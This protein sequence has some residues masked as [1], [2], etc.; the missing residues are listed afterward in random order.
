MRRA[1]S[2][3]RRRWVGPYIWRWRAFL[4]SRFRRCSGLS[5]TADFASTRLYDHRMKRH[6]VVV[7]VAVPIF[8]VLARWN[9]VVAVLFAI[10]VLTWILTSLYRRSMGGDVFGNADM[11]KRRHD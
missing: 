6:L 8:L 10:A 1:N 5:I 9:G 4:T 3:R 11:D 7:I 2:A